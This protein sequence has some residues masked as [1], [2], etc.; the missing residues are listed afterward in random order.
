[1][2]PKRGR[3]GFT[4][5]LGQF[6]KTVSLAEKL[7]KGHKR[8]QFTTLL[9]RGQQA[10][11]LKYDALTVYFMRKKT[12]VYL[13]EITLEALEASTLKAQGATI[14]RA[15]EQYAIIGMSAGNRVSL[16]MPIVW[17]DFRETTA[18]LQAQ[19]VQQAKRRRAAR[20]KP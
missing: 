12:V 20:E 18:R 19:A 11:R 6:G 13:D 15:I 8:P 16:A 1:M 5:F 10:I 4:H 3:V 7:Q 9:I 17:Q 14:S 2:Y